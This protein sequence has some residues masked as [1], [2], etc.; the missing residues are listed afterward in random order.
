MDL[1]GEE[2]PEFK[3][4]E[5]EEDKEA[6]EGKRRRTQEEE[7]WYDDFWTDKDRTIGR[8]ESTKLKG[9]LTVGSKR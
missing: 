2:S 9:M 7:D 1:F 6:P 5:E 4:K 8:V 3:R